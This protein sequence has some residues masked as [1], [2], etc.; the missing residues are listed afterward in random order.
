MDH[1]GFKHIWLKLE[2]GV[3]MYIFPLIC[4]VFFL[5]ISLRDRNLLNPLLLIKQQACIKEYIFY[6]YPTPK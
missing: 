3:C 2:W 4:K 6:G 5:D 1:S